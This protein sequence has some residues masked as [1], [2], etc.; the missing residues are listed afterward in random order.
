MPR[1][2]N[3]WLALLVLLVIPG[4]WIGQGLG[5]LALPGEV[6]G[7]SIAGWTLVLQYYFRK[8]PPNGGTPPRGA[9]PH[10]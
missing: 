9:E 5:W 7:A 2:W 6:L 3:D 4:L 8:A 10:G 1:S